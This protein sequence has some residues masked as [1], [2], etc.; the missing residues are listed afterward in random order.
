MELLFE[1]SIV[2]NVDI[3]GFFTYIRDN[4]EDVAM[5]S[6]E[7]ESIEKIDYNKTD[8]YNTHVKRLFRPTPSYIPSILSTYNEYFNYYDDA[9]WN[10]K[11]HTIDNLVYPVNGNLYKIKGNI[12]FEKIDNSHIQVVFKFYELERSNVPELIKNVLFKLI[13]QNSKDFLKLSEEIYKS[14]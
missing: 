8:K 2:L 1:D 3:N 10:S 12:Q 4:M 11:H 5:V 14:L 13:I 6:T 7:L 9:V